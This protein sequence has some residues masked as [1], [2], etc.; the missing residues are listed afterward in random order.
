MLKFKFDMV[1]SQ[2]LLHGLG[3]FPW[4]FTQSS[5]WKDGS[6]T[7]TN[8]QEIRNAHGWC[9]QEIISARSSAATFNGTIHKWSQVYTLQ[10][11]LRISHLKDPKP[12]MMSLALVWFSGAKPLIWFCKIWMPCM[13]V[14][15]CLVSSCSPAKAF[16]TG[17]HSAQ[18][19]AC[20]L[21]FSK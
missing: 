7:E 3:Y 5:R 19:F 17:G 13:A 10:E 12:L 21:A 18:V 1:P 11:Q 4:F 20:L 2:A 14:P 8:C 6:P 9:E 16:C 15:H